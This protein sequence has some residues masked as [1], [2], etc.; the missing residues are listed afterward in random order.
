MLSLHIINSGQPPNKLSSF[1]WPVK[2]SVG[3]RT[4]GLYSIPCKCGK[5][6]IGQMDRSMDMS[7]KEH[8]QH[9]PLEHPD[10]PAEAEHSIKL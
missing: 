10:K 2:D 9:I 1:H 8:Q 4:P 3:L 5:V 7:L 6:Y